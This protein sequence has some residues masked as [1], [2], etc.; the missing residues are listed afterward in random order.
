VANHVKIH[1]CL[2]PALK[3][4]NGAESPHLDT[5][6]ITIPNDSFGN[7]RSVNQ[8]AG[9][10]IRGPLNGRPAVLARSTASMI[11][12]NVVSRPIRSDWISIA[13]D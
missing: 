4:D 10:S 9:E 11:P 5:R 12:P 6:L 3:A 1:N 13:P 2:H 7:H 8:V